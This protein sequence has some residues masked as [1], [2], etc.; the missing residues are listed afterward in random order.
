M[1]PSK[2]PPPGII[3]RAKEGFRKA[4]E[5]LQLKEKVSPKSPRTL[6]TS[7]PNESAD[8]LIPEQKLI[9]EKIPEQKLIA[10]PKTPTTSGKPSVRNKS[11]EQLSNSESVTDQE[12]FQLP[13]SE[14]PNTLAT[15][16]TYKTDFSIT[17]KYMKEHKIPQTA[18][19][20]LIYA[21]DMF[22]QNTGLLDG[23]KV[24][25]S[26][27]EDTHSSFY[28]GKKCVYLWK[29]YDYLNEPNKYL[30]GFTAKECA[31]K[32][33]W[34]I[35]VMLL[36]YVVLGVQNIH[37]LQPEPGTGSDRNTGISKTT[38]RMLYQFEGTS[39]TNNAI[40]QQVP[41]T[42]LDQ[43]LA[44]FHHAIKLQRQFRDLK[45]VFDTFNAEEKTGIPEDNVIEYDTLQQSIS[46]ITVNYTVSTCKYGE[47]ISKLKENLKGK[48]VEARINSGYV[49][50]YV[51][52]RP[53]S[54]NNVNDPIINA[55]YQSKNDVTAYNQKCSA[56]VCENVKLQMRTYSKGNPENL[57]EE[58]G[59]FSTFFN[60]TSK[61]ENVGEKLYDQI[62]G[63][64]NINKPI[65]I[66][67]Y[68]YS[69]S[70]KSYTLFGGDTE[71]GAISNAL[72]RFGDLQIVLTS[73]KVEL[74]KFNGK[75]F[76]DITLTGEHVEIYPNK[77][78]GVFFLE[79]YFQGCK[80]PTTSTGTG[81]TVSENNIKSN[82]NNKQQ[83]N[84]YLHN[85]EVAISTYLNDTLRIRPTPNNIKSSRC[86][87]FVEFDISQGDKTSKLLVID[88]A[89]RENPEN[90]LGDFKMNTSILPSMVNVIKGM[91]LQMQYYPLIN[92]FLLKTKN[93]PNNKLQDC[94]FM[95]NLSHITRSD[96]TA[97]VRLL[98]SRESSSSYDNYFREGAGL[99][100]IQ[101]LKQTGRQKGLT[102]IFSMID[103][104]HI[105]YDDAYSKI[106]EA[107][108]EDKNMNT[109]L[110]EKAVEKIKK[111]LRTSKPTA[112]TIA[113][114]VCTCLEGY[115]INSTLDSLKQFFNL[116]KEHLKTKVTTPIEKTTLESSTPPRSYKILD[117]AL[118]PNIVSTI[119]CVPRFPHFLNTD[120]YMKA[121]YVMIV[122]MREDRDLTESLNFAD[123]MSASSVSKTTNPVSSTGKGL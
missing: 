40:P 89:G 77:E 34:N 108:L 93:K 76:G 54:V 48:Y 82:G 27:G 58:Y 41:A 95:G 61:N 39:E 79:D 101:I 117:D 106:Y 72:S 36:Q 55:Y 5:A 3:E 62:N 86:H 31:K 92:N 49:H 53:D 120:T 78:N 2:K 1:L 88:M 87:T 44:I 69:G 103:Q 119:T 18:A 30:V 22:Q 17:Q 100:T 11:T 75:N 51:K 94:L 19:G 37:P 28:G 107:E 43:K 21:H 38:I 4:A 71:H 115:Y 59:E 26:E 10:E 123:D 121:N 74:I 16:T 56:S 6:T 24:L 9:A 110:K 45:S 32:L 99:F 15:T 116:R 70:G 8:G 83:V 105:P 84:T 47:R 57:K 20:V 113:H 7:N 112:Y 102:N 25:I 73:V 109:E 66:F 118:K 122:N 90:I 104:T 42:P 64:L 23:A 50:V 33:D 52:V 14:G 65:V 81:V 68:G 98:H 111:D 12:T 29:Y 91:S 96:L 67:S 13:I 97:M 63:C 46:D 85:I 35:F 60:H 114:I 80:I